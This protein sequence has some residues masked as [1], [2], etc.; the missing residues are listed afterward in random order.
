MAESC[1]WGQSFCGENCGGSAER[2]LSQL[3]ARSIDRGGWDDLKPSL[4]GEAA[5]D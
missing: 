3:A 5:A 1:G 2:E 4:A